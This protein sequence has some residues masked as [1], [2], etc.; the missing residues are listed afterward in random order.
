ME[1][2]RK[3]AA[4]VSICF[5]P[6]MGN[7]SWLEWP[8]SLDVSS[9]L[10]E[11]WRPFPFR[12]FIVKVH[13]RCDLSCDYCYM[14]EMADQS[15]RGR[16]RTMSPETAE[17]TARRIADHANAHDLRDITLI[18][19]GGEPLLAGRDLISRLVTS[20]RHLAGPKT[21]VNASVQ[22]NGVGLSD[23]YLGLFDELG[24]RIGVSLD[25]DAGAHDRHRRFASGRG[26][27]EAVAAA[28]RRLRRFPHLYGGLLCTIDLSNDPVRTY[29]ALADFDPPKIDFLLPHGTWGDPPPG[30]IPDSA[31]TPYADWL[32][33]VFDYWYPKPQTRVRLFEEIMQLLL[34]GA[35]NSEIVGL[36][37][38][39]M[40][41]I[42]TDGSV[43]QEDTLKVAYDGAAATGLNV[44]R[45]ALDAALLLPQIVARQ[46]GAKALSAPCRACPVRAVC[47]GG[48][49]SHRYR[50]GTGFFNP[51]VYC[52]DLLTLISHIRSRLQADLTARHT[53]KAPG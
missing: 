41:V 48:L 19:H 1:R 17:L 22:T 9:L 23:A 6:F 10:A 33:E 31:S 42:E 7:P 35:S 36:A 44:A 15:W 8:A 13:S 25:G 24:V 30:R 43:E 26:S 50:E 20:T 14:Y 52:P 4:E 28:L 32:T 37:P 45:D 2:Y 53:M 5:N 29:R 18:L 12:E 27:Y 47:G 3:I 38:A 34:G 46:I 21:T 40:V 51:S 49:Y 39:R 16:P 11:G